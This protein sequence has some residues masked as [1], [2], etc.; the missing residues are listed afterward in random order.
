[1]KIRHRNIDFTFIKN[2]DANGFRFVHNK[3]GLGFYSRFQNSLQRVTN[4]NAKSVLVSFI[5]S[6][7]E[8]VIILLENESFINQLKK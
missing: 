8:R 6:N 3:T 5:E 4:A 2:G 1:M 7:P